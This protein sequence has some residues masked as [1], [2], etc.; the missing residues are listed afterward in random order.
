MIGF[1]EV[2]GLL[3]ASAIIGTI[4]FLIGRWYEQQKRKTPP[5]V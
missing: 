2:F 3:L 1:L 4:G 5:E